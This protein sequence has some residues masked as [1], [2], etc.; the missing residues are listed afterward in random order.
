[1]ADYQRFDAKQDA[2]GY[3]PVNRAGDTMTGALNLPANG[4]NVGGGQLVATGGNVGIGTGAPKSRLHVVGDLVLGNDVNGQKFIFH[5]RSSA[6]GDFLQITGDNASGNW[7]WGKGI[8]FVRST[9]YVG[10]NT[11]TPG[12]LLEIKYGNASV[13]FKPTVGNFGNDI[14]GAW[15]Y[16]GGSDTCNGNVANEY[17][18]GINESRTCQDV[19][20][21]S[22]EYGSYYMRR[23]ITCYKETR[24]NPIFTDQLE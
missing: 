8:T 24:I 13:S 10:I 6:N 14:Y 3:T 1:A 22:D 16:G 19:A 4:L 15:A 7:E 18:C 21:F 17:F 20:I 11:T 5:S 23:T 12:G 2:L 9:G